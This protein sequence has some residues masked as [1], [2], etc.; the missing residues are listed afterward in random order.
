MHIHVYTKLPLLIIKHTHFIVVYKLKIDNVKII[1]F[2]VT[3]TVFYKNIYTPF[4]NYQT[5][6]FNQP[7][8]LQIYTYM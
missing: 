8:S 6:L 1:K 2:T 7:L 3:V 5:A 4:K